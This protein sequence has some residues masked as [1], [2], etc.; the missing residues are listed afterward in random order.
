MCWPKTQKQSKTVNCTDEH[1]VCVL[2][3]RDSD[4]RFGTGMT[5]MMTLMVRDVLHTLRSRTELGAEAY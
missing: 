2:G 1:F 4:R 3:M 5:L